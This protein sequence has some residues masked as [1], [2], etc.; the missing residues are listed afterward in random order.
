MKTFLVALDG[1][2]RAA[3]VL[4]AAANLAGSTDARLVL[5]RAVSLPADLPIE[6]YAMSPDGVMSLL[7][8]RASAELNELARKVLGARPYD[9]RVEIGTAWQSICHTAKEERAAL[10]IV[11]SHGY[12]P[13]DRLLG[14]TAAKIVNHADR[15]VLVVRSA[16]LLES[17]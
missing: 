9:V 15:S 6:A 3:E 4:S 1:S 10:I 16:S 5:F 2:P 11:G 14:T 17:V 13:I 12:A 7:L 8:Q